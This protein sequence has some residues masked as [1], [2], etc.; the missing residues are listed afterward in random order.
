[1]KPAQGLPL[2]VMQG[3]L[4]PKHLG[5]YQAHP[6]GRWREEFP[7]A[8]SLGLCC[9]EFI[10][11]FE[12]AR[13][14]P[15]LSAEG[16]RDIARTAHESGVAVRTVCADYFMA[17]PLHDPSP[18]TA[19]R[20]A[21]V[22]RELLRLA[23]AVGVACVVVPCVDQSSLSGDPAAADRLVEALSPYAREAGEAG[24]TLALETDLSPPE[25]AALLSR[26]PTTIGVNYDT[27]NSAA[28]GFD[29]AEEM[30]AY[31]DRVA[32]VHIKDR[33][34][35]GGSVELGQ[36]AADFDRFFEALA[37]TGFSG[38]FIMQ[39]YRDD[40]GTAVFAR[41]LQGIVPRI[42]KYTETL[43]AGPRTS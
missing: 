9:I 7:L 26:L 42:R 13:D 23:P 14:N 3:R 32:S 33:T 6:V 41:Q 8:A 35:G 20:S 2:G 37:R 16:A 31:G 15:L 30:A 36:G 38:P 39:A 11:D 5:R 21:Q 19:A 17:A 10:L 12:G 43:A 27:G 24:V 4:L 28:L 1:M 34:L 22:L 25:F 40:E 29:P 18:R